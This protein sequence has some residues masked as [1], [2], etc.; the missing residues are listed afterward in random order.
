MGAAGQ[1]VSAVPGRLSDISLFLELTSE[2]VL[3]FVNYD[4]KDD[5]TSVF[6]RAGIKNP[7]QQVRMIYAEDKRHRGNSTLTFMDGHAEIRRLT[8]EQMGFRRIFNPL[9]DTALY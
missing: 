1:K 2:R 8:R 9:D 7:P 4:V 6:S 3:D 5:Q